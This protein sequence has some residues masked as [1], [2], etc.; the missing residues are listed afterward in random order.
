MIGKIK[1]MIPIRGRRFVDPP[2]EDK[3]KSHAD[4]AVVEYKKAGQSDAQ[5]FSKLFESDV[6]FR[7]SWATVTEAKHL[8]ALKSYPGMMRTDP[9]VIGGEVSAET[10]LRAL[11]SNSA[12]CFAMLTRS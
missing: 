11:Q 7:K 5:A 12:T 8:L 10:S 6:D 9:A 1:D 4:R 2:D 3:L